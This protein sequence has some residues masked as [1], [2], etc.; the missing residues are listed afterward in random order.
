MRRVARAR[1]VLATV[2][3]MT[4]GLLAGCERVYPDDSS[5]PSTSMAPCAGS[6]AATVELGVP[7]RGH[8]PAMI[9]TNGDP[10]YFSARGF[11]TGQAFDGEPR[12]T[13]FVGPEDKPPFYD[14]ARAEVTTPITRQVTVHEERP[15][16]LDLPAGRYW[17]W[18]RDDVHVVAI[19]CTSRGVT[20]SAAPVGP[21]FSECP[22]SDRAADDT[23]ADKQWQR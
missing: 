4:V 17:V 9:V 22:P 5:Q 20:G 1:A 21:S 14:S 8:A 13:L 10:L 7:Y 3:A 19:S 2:L 11:R 12:T 16:K 15:S 6:P 18:T 23:C